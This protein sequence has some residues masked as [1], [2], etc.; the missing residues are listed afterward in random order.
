MSTVL[1][2]EFPARRY[3]ATPWGQH[4]NEGAVE[5][6]P[7]PW[8]ILRALLATGFTKHAWPADQPPPVARHLFET[9]SSVTPRYVLPSVRL[10]H[11][12]HFVSAGKKQVLI[13][14]TWARLQDGAPPLEVEW[15]CDLGSAERDVLGKLAASLGYL[16]RAESWVI[17]ALGER[18]EG[19]P[20]CSTERP[21]GSGWDLVRLMCPVGVAEYETWRKEMTDA[22]DKRLP[23]PTAKKPTKKLLDDREKALAPYPRDLVTALCCET[24]VIQERGWSS[25]P[26]SK[27]VVYWRP[28]EAMNAKP[29]PTARSI[30]PPVKVPFVLLALSTP[31]RNRSGLPS[32]SRVFPQ[33]RLLHRALAAAVGRTGARGVAPVLLGRDGEHV[34][35]GNHSHA[36]LIHLSLAGEADGDRRLDHALVWAPAGIDAD[37]L[38]ALRAIRRTY[39]KGGVGELQ[40]ALAATGD[41]QSLLALDDMFQGGLSAVLGPR[42]GA[43][44]WLSATPFVAARRTKPRGKDSIVGQVELEASRRGLG[45][46][47]VHVL[48]PGSESR[49]ALR[50]H[51]LHDRDHRPPM[52]VTH[53]LRL[54]FAQPVPGPVCLGWGAHYGLGCF[55]AVPSPAQRP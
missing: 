20:N 3:H 13:L 14:D 33:G 40:V 25:P 39:M 15:P 48:P 4:V 34:S 55:K 29:A 37:G 45:Q 16:G 43:R 10:A 51:V 46:V 23:L 22:V 19:A 53:A 11:S 31:S 35:Q 24:G 5:W 2:F 27:E 9:L 54:S 1:R 26:G 41:L 8:R 47:E 17:G 21:A 38:R 49:M 7:S 50:R 18:L 12:R 36:H 44:E 52:A 6:P 30:C 32:D 28:S 42:G